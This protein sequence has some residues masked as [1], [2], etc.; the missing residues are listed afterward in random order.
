MKKEQNNSQ[1]NCYFYWKLWASH[2]GRLPLNPGKI[3]VLGADQ[4]ART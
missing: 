3:R 4:L 1:E 2:E